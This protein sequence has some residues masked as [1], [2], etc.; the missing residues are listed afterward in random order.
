M[1]LYVDTYGTS[2]VEL[3]DGE[4]ARKLEE[5]FDMRPYAIETRFSLRSPIYSETAAYGHM[6]RT[7][8]HIDKEFQ[9]ASG[10]KKKVN[11]KLFPWEDTDYVTRVK[12]A[13]GV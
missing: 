12:E 7:C 6:G 5:I 10:Q 2:K 4:I 9:D 1:G 13:F 8:K 3:T 11:V